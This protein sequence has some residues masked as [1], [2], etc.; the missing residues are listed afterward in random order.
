MYRNKP[1]AASPEIKVPKDTT[2]QKIAAL[3]SKL[4]TVSEKLNQVIS[5]NEQLRK[6]IRR[7]AQDINLLT[8]A[9]ARK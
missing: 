9:I 8:N 2:D 4:N 1:A 5:E 7:G 3:E 6:A